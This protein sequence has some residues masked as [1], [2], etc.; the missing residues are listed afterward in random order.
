MTLT[1]I[2]KKE[3]RELFIANQPFLIGGHDIT[4]EGA[5]WQ[6]KQLLPQALKWATGKW[7]DKLYKDDFNALVA[8]FRWRFCTGQ[9][10]LLK[11]EYAKEA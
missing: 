7:A 1:P 3:A 2:T 8:Y 4:G 5:Y 9:G 6:W 10:R 11:I